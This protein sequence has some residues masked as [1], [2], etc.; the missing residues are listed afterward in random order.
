MNRMTCRLI[1][2][3]ATVLLCGSPS[4]QPGEEAVSVWIL[5]FDHAGDGGDELGATIADLL[6]LSFSRSPRY[7]VV[8][9][10]ALAEIL[11]ERSVAAAGLARPGVGAEKLLWARRMLHGTVSRRGSS[12]LITAHVTDVESTRILVSAQVSG[13]AAALA[14][15]VQ[16][17]TAE[18]MSAPRVADGGSRPG[19]ADPAPAAN[20]HF[21]RGLSHY[22]A[23]QYHRALAEFLRSGADP[24]ARALSA[25]WRANCYIAT[26]RHAHAF[27]ELLRLRREGLGR[28]SPDDLQ[29]LLDECREHLSADEIRTYRGL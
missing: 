5:P 18:L 28:V 10:Q 23:R 11:A 13:E 21:L 25:L 4:A 12:L 16:E 17:L 8:D 9:R 20:L 7:A 19:E 1:A 3:L 14:C 15:L 2:A 29:R 27:L 22:H 6:T 24:E 26:E